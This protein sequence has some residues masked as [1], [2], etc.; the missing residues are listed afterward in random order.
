MYSLINNPSK[1]NI[2]L[3]FSIWRYLLSSIP[4][5]NPD[6]WNSL[7]LTVMLN[8]NWTSLTW[9][10]EDS[11]ILNKSNYEFWDTVVTCTSGKHGSVSVLS[12]D[13]IKFRNGKTIKVEISL[14]KFKLSLQEIKKNAYLLYNSTLGKYFYNLQTKSTI[15][16]QN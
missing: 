11:K 10:R 7:D 6:S 14:I 3:K 12:T 13:K 1:D 9:K 4:T 15:R 16:C 2:W 5:T 8:T